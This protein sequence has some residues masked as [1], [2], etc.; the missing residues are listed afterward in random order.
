MIMIDQVIILGA[1][2]LAHVM[3]YAA[4]CVDLAWTAPLLHVLDEGTRDPV[5]EPLLLGALHG[6]TSDISMPAARPYVASRTSHAMPPL[7]VDSPPSMRGLLP[8]P[9]L[10]IITSPSCGY[11]RDGERPLAPGRPCAWCGHT[12]TRRGDTT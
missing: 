8:A 4:L 12:P 1:G 6:A 2:A 10:T 7:V 11:C 3:V 5:T 9:G